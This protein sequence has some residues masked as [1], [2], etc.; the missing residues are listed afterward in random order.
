MQTISYTIWPAATLPRRLFKTLKRRR[1]LR[2]AKASGQVGELN[3]PI[4]GD[5]YVVDTGG[6][7][8]KRMKRMTAER[9]MRERNVVAVKASLYHAGEQ[10]ASI[11]VGGESGDRR[12]RFC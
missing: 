10:R 3:K 2:G 7:R 1:F 9:Y 5:K 12:I 8:M 4:S 11:G 6:K